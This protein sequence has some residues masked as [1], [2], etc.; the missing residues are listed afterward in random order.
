MFF[1]FSKVAY[2]F[3]SPE[4]WIIALILI[5]LI[6]RPP[7]V[8]KRLKVALL[9]AIFFFGNEY[10][11]TELVNAW[12]PRPVKLPGNAT[13]DAGILLGGLTS[14]DQNRIGFFNGAS[15]RFIAASTLYKTGKIRKIIVSGGA[16]KKNVPLE[17]DYLYKRLIDIGVATDDIIVEN[18]SRTT[19]E[20]AAFT[21]QMLDSLHLKEPLI[22]VTSAVHVPRAERVFKKAGINVISFPC[23]YS[24]LN[25]RMG[26]F[27]FLIPSLSTI[28]S[29]SGFLKEVVGLAGYTIFDKA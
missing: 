10:I 5:I 17:G 16:L 21:K 23:H 11:Y 3:L 4:N 26:I 2:F 8:K 22:L 7:V 25:K 20:N 12:Q 6:T 9:V 14:F 24:V 29:W 15:D 27:N 1:F 18:R 19:F 13:Y 28:V